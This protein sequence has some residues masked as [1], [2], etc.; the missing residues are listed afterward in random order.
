MNM[1]AKNAA[2]SIEEYFSLLPKEHK[3]EFEFLHNFIQKQ[4]LN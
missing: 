3:K 2:K 1:F 4:F